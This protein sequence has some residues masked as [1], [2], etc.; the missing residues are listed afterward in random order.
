MRG[1]R[2]K[3]DSIVLCTA[4]SSR[5]P[6]FGTRLHDGCF[7]YIAGL[8]VK[9]ID[10]EDGLLTAASSRSGYV[11]KLKDCVSDSAANAPLA[12]GRHS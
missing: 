11:A 9:R 5:P 10:V 2:A 4:N 3:I 1:G 7:C 12:T 8:G 6:A